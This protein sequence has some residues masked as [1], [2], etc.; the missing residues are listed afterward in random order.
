[1]EL[2]RRRPLLSSSSTSVAAV[3]VDDELAFLVAGQEVYVRVLTTPQV[4]ELPR[5]LLESWGDQPVTA[6][7]RDA[8]GA[9]IGSQPVWL[10]WT[11]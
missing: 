1:M 9:V 5:S 2:S 6:I 3:T 7:F 11:P 4:V 8:H 10:I